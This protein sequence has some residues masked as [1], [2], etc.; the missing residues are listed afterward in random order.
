MDINRASEGI[1]AEQ[2]DDAKIT[3]GIEHG[4]H[5]S[6]RRRGTQLRQRD[7]EEG[8]PGTVAET[9]GGLFQ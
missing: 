7:R 6:R 2:G 4:Q 3:Q 1:V 9:A 5:P 8:A